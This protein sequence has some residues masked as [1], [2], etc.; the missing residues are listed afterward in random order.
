MPSLEVDCL[1]QFAVYVAATGVDDYGDK[2]GAAAI[3]IKVR[4]E[5]GLS[6]IVDSFGN[7]ISID[8]TV[9]VDRVIAIGSTMWQGKLED[10]PATSADLRKVVVYKEIP[11]TKGREF[12]RV[13]LLRKLSDEVLATT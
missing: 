10:Y 9:V 7:T 11:D 1:N 13:V 3:E 4:W 12:R 2:T 8:A 6:E 5:K